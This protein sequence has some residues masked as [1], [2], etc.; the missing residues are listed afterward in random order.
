MEVKRC[1]T[2]KGLSLQKERGERDTS[3][4][5][6]MQGQ[7]TWGLADVKA[8]RTNAKG[9]KLTRKQAAERFVISLKSLQI[10]KLYVDF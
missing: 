2:D 6:D 1:E 7:S 9:T 4:D 10:V 8:N 3:F 5:I